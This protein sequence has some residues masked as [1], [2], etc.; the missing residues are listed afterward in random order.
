MAWGIGDWLDGLFYHLASFDDWVA[1]TPGGCALAVAMLA[2]GV[3]LF[4]LAGRAVL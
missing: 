2:I 1:K 4:I 3:T